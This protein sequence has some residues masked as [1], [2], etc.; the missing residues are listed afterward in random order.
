MHG[1]LITGYMETDRMVTLGQQKV[2]S[3]PTGRAILRQ[4]GLLL[5][6]VPAGHADAIASLFTAA[7]CTFTTVDGQPSYEADS[8]GNNEVGV[9]EEGP[10]MALEEIVA[11]AQGTPRCLV[12]RQL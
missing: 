4:G 3:A 10:F 7:A 11:D 1:L 9:E 5:L 6:E 8:S 12:L 2:T